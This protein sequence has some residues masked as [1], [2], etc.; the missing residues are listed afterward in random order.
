MRR[1]QVWRRKAKKVPPP[2]TPQPPAEPPVEVSAVVE[3]PAQQYF[4][5]FGFK[6]HH[7]L[8]D[9]TILERLRHGHP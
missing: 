9:A 2:V 4:E 5:R 7:R 6:P 1:R 8:K 3:P